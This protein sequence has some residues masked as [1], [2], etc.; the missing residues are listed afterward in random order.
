MLRWPDGLVEA[1]C[2]GCLKE[3]PP[4]FMRVSSAI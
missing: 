2:D 4:R 1:I 3:G